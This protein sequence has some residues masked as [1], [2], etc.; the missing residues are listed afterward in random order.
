MHGRRLYNISAICIAPPDLLPSGGIICINNRRM[1][2]F[3]TYILP[4]SAIL[5]RFYLGAPPFL[6]RFYIL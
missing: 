3:Y 2:G 4:K 5:H 1:Y 6:H